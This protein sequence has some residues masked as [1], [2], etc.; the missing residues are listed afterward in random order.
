ML[1]GRGWWCLFCVAVML[2]AGILRGLTG[3]TVTGL[4]LLLWLGWEW[5]TFTARVKTLARRLRVE[6][7]L[8]DERGPVATLWVGRVF[9]VRV[10]LRL[11][12][13]GKVPHLAASDPVPFD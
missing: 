7:E 4:A 6:R 1:S 2:L 3:L 10:L 5:L 9:T 12:G 8:R 11:R 13:A